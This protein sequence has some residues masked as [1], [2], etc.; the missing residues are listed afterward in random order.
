MTVAAVEHAVTLC[1][2]HLSAHFVGPRPELVAG[3]ESALRVVLPPSYRRFVET[4]GAGIL[5][6]RRRRHGRRVCPRH[7]QGPEPPVEVWYGGASTSDDLLERVA[8]SFGDFFLDGV[9][10]APAP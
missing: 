7:C 9:R 4:L 8:D 10:E 5:G 1:Q 2:H 3:A 6:D